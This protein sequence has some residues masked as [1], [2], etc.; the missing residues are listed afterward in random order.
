MRKNLKKRILSLGLAIALAATLFITSGV[1]ALAYKETTG[2]VSTDNVKV[3]SSASTTASQVSSLKNGDKIDIVDEATDASGYVWYKIRVNKSEFGYVRSDLITKADGTGPSTSTNNNATTSET[4]TPLPETQVTATEQKT[5]TIT[6]ESVNVRKGAGTGY[7]SV[8]KVTKGNTVTITGEAT[9]TDNKTW[10]QISFGNGK[11]GFVRGDLLEIGEAAPVE[12]PEGTEGGETPE[13][14]EG[15]EETPAETTEATD[16]QA[17]TGVTNTVGDGSYALQ[18]ETDEEGVSKWYLYD[19]TGDPKY[20]VLVD[21]LINAAKSSDKVAKLQKTNKTYKTFLIILAIIIAALVL[22]VI[23][24]A[25]KLRDSI[26]YEDDEEDEYDRYSPAPRRRARDDDEEDEEPRRPRRPASD[27]RTVRPERDEAAR[28]T[29]PVRRD[30]DPEE[31]PSR[32]RRSAE[33]DAPERPLRRSEERPSRPVRRED[34]APERPSKRTEE[35]PKRR[36]KN[37]IGDEDDFEFEFLDLDDD[38]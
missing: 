2:T 13:N 23:L 6:S 20:R 33:D 11:Q 38:K 7:D 26:Y 35:A 5:A 10:Y 16:T 34:D 14:T 1:E 12:T 4:S 28:P 25:L 21:E 18:Y 3:R 37:F 36:A 30:V 32:P 22:G 31:R 17:G 27:D 8:G 24:L 9:G 15:T 19:Y 29:R